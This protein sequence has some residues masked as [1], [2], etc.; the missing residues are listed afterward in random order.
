M[1]E[2]VKV[3]TAGGGSRTNWVAINGSDPRALGPQN[4]TLW[5]NTTAGALEI[6]PYECAAFVCYSDYCGGQGFSA[7][8]RNDKDLHKFCEGYWATVIG[9]VVFLV[10]SS[11][12][13]FVVGAR[14][15]RY[16]KLYDCMELCE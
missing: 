14:S 9:H 16:T 12:I 6:L 11:V 15:S 4:D 1:G 7:W 10:L 3:T 13:V 5:L 8:K 2:P